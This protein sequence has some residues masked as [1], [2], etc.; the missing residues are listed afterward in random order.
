MLCGFYNKEERS[1]HIGRS[2]TRACDTGARLFTKKSVRY[3]EALQPW[4][5]MTTE[6]K[7]VHMDERRGGSVMSTCSARARTY[8]KAGL[9]GLL[10]AGLAQVW[11][12]YPVL[13]E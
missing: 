6:N 12:D 4:R 3:S 5:E 8:I 9:L 13:R 1:K 10:A 2:G 11:W 7:R